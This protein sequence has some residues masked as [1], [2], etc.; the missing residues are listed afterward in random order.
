VRVYHLL[1]LEHAFDDLK[2]RRLKVAEFGDLN[3]P[4]ELLST[5]IADKHLRQ[6]HAAWRR[7]AMFRYG[8]ICFSRSWENPVLW[9]HYADKHRGICL[10]FDVPD[11]LLRTV[12][13][14][15]TRAPLDGFLESG[16]EN[17]EP[18][19]LFYT[20][21]SHWQYED[22][23]RRIVE[24][25]KAVHQ[26]KHHFWPFGQELEL[27]EVVGGSRCDVTEGQLRDVLGGDAKLI[28]LTKARPAFTKFSIVT[29]KRGFKRFNV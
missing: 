4:F 10:G 7:N 25:D 29:Q 22:E 27:K 1:S 19:A 3:D 24:L 18:G 5:R 16:T 28:R 9:S 11:P 26:D 20:K 21:F 14:L 6:R 23:V 17:D 12:R 2:H 8:V 15:E 13:Y